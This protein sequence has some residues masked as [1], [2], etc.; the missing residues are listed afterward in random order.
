MNKIPEATEKMKAFYEERT[1]KHIDRV[2][3]N[4]QKVA[5]NSPHREELIQRGKDHDASKYGEFEK[6]LYIWLT[7]FHRCKNEGIDFKYPD[8]AEEKVDEATGH[9]VHINKHHPEAHESIND[10][11]EVDIIEMVCDWTAM[12]QELGDENGSARSWAD[13]NVGTKWKFNDGQKQLIYDTIE[14]LEYWDS[15]SGGE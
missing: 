8:G 14:A 3:K 2:I 12:A 13:K 4:I 6:P 1:K 10:M 5:V 15:V 11:N 9:H 7:E